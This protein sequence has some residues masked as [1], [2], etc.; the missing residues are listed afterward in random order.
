MPLISSSITPQRRPPLPAVM[1]IGRARESTPPPPSEAAFRSLLK[2][3]GLLKRVMEPYFARFGVS[4]SQ[5]GVLITL[6][7]CEPEGGQTGLRLTDLGDRLIVRPASVTGVVDR[8]QRMGL[9]DRT[10]SASDHRA[11]YV[12]LTAAGRNLVR[13]IL[14]DHPTQVRRAFDGLSGAEQGHFQ[15]LLERMS[16]HLEELAGAA[17]A[18]AA[19]KSSVIR[20]PNPNLT[21]GLA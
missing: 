18:S 3:L 13:R 7:R 21:A 17:G 6:H 5:W 8:L 9:V 12:N 14:E 4:G 10:A 19:A 15:Q 20:K 2:T 11:K 1:T 16:T